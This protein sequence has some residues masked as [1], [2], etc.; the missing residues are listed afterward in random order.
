MILYICTRKSLISV[1]LIKANS[2]AAQGKY[3]GGAGSAAASASLYEAN[4]QY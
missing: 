3:T 2:E 1:P 4:R